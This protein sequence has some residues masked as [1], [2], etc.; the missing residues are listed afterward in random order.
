[1]NDEFRTT[2][3]S[4]MRDLQS[5][6]ESREGG[7]NMEKEELFAANEEVEVVQ[8]ET[9][10]EEAPAPE[11]EFSAEAE[12][13]ESQEPVVEE[14]PEESVEEKYSLLEADHK[15]LQSKFEEQTELIKELLAFKE[16]IE[17]QQKD[18]LIDS[19]YMLSDED[20]KDVIE[21]K[22]NYSLDEIES[23]LAVVCVRNKVSFDRDE[24][25]DS[26]ENQDSPA[27]TF[28]LEDTVESVPAYI[29]ALRSVK[30]D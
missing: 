5:A 16:K 14:E 23:K 24:E 22:K 19:F 28:N 11:E 8:E 17:D 15:E 4:M 29:Q 2:L 30:Q 21:N 12:V 6:I 9:L 3:F 7:L 25:G 13:E 26:S 18:A 20:K 27:V 10:E 1:M